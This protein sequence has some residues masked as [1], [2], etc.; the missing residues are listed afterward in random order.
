MRVP[1]AVVLGG[2]WYVGDENRLILYA[3]RFEWV[4]APNYLLRLG[5]QTC[6]VGNPALPYV[7]A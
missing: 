4:A 3:S 2:W 1:I 6:D 7:L 5:L